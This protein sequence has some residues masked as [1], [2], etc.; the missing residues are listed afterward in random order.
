MNGAQRPRRG[1]LVNAFAATEDPE[2]ITQIL[3]R[4]G[5]RAPMPTLK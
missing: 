5:I 3:H 2:I 1:D 4:V